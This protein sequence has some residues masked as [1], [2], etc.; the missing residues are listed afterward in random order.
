MNPEEMAISFVS[1][2]TEETTSKRAV[3]GTLQIE[4]T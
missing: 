2:P 4:I 1:K 3:A